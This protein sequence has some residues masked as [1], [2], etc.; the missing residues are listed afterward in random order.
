MSMAVS[1]SQDVL[2]PLVRGTNLERSEARDALAQILDGKIEAPLIASFLTALTAKG[3]TAVE[4]TGFVDA[5]IASATT[6]SVDP[7]A[8]DIVGT[9]G[10]Q[11]HTVNISTMASLAVAG[12]GVKIAK[13]GNRAAS[14]SVGSADVLEALGVRLDAPA[15]IV[16]ACVEEAG[17]GFCFAPT[18]HHAL[19]YLTPIRRA[20]GFR[21]A[22]NVLGPLANP[23][24]VS[25]ALIGVSQNQIMEQMAAVLGVRGIEFEILV[26]SDDGI[27]VISLGSNATLHYVTDSSIE[28][29]RVDAAKELGISHDVSAIRGG[30]VATNVEVVRSFL[31]GTQG[32]VFDVVCANAGL[33]LIVAGKATS[34][35]EGFEIAKQSVLSGSAGTALEKLV[36]I[37]NS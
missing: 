28:T 24:L 4:M 1:F 16:K 20:L 6:F 5:M 33:A 22:F 7:S 12:S 27:D 37:S 30:D 8:M 11:L 25:K 13:H 21:T 29:K 36:A 35:A 18:F 23:A 9:G 3:E 34:I 2:N 32:P 10:D 17:I 31:N 19:G 15:E 14:S 26:H